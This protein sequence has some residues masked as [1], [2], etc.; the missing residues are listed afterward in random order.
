MADL[1]S[2]RK[3]VCHQRSVIVS[4]HTVSPRVDPGPVANQ[5]RAWSAWSVALAIF[6]PGISIVAA[7]SIWAAGQSSAGT[8]M[9]VV[10][11]AIAPV[12]APS[13]GASGMSGMP[14]MTTTA[15]APAAATTVAPH[16]PV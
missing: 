11:P 9:P 4:T 3:S 6:I 12:V 16:T 14:D 2:E 5:R 8:A 15:S 13:P 1:S 10:A 7:V